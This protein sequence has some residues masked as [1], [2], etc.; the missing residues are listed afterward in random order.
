MST[1]IEVNNFVFDILCKISTFT[2]AVNK[3]CYNE[4]SRFLVLL[5]V[6]VVSFNNSFHKV[7]TFLSLY[8]ALSVA[9]K[10]VPEKKTVKTHHY[11]QFVI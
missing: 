6:F 8:F 1:D 3:K 9:N 5:R 2:F 7:Q 10:Y 4:S 11:L